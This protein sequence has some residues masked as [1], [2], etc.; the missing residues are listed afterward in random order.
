MSA[1]ATPAASPS[2]VAPTV[3]PRSGD[4]RD[5]GAV[6]RDFVR[7]QRWSASGAVKILGDVDVDEASLSGLSSIRG[8][9]SGGTFSA[10]G[11]CDIGGSVTLTGALRGAGTTTVRKGVVAAEIELSGSASISGPIQATGLVR[12]R[13]VLETTDDLRAGRVEFEG[14][15][16]V[17]GAVVAKE[18]EGRIRGDSRF[19]S[20]QADRVRITRPGR[21]FGRGQ[22]TVLTIEAKDVELEGVEAQ[23]VKA[24]RVA[25]GPGCQIAQV[26]G[27]ITRQHPS[28]H[29]GPAS[30][31]PPPYGLMR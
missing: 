17:P 31:T 5:A 22:L 3:L 23:H 12:W 29:V 26:D 14:R 30:R 18:V 21:L 8:N 28:A 7:A 24:E 1:S 27:T 16:A 25:L 10:A 19:G 6:R 2:P 15:G 11:T 13:G 4:I 20:I 9:V